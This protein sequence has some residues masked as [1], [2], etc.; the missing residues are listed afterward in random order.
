MKYDTKICFIKVSLR[1]TDNILLSQCP[2]FIY[3]F[4]L[5]FLNTSG[6]SAF[7][8]RVHRCHRCAHHLRH[9][10]TRRS[11]RQHSSRH[12]HHRQQTDEVDHQ[13]SYFQV[14][15]FFYQSPLSRYIKFVYVHVLRCPLLRYSSLPHWSVEPIVGK[16]PL[17]K[18]TV[19][20]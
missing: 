14:S 9:H 2:M 5:P 18:D 12:R 15:S 6:E 19:E 20:I 16:D 10:C 4:F 11:L 3:L 8:V 17:P 7:R 13:L 1:F